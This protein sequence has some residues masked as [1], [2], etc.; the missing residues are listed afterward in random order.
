M[1][2]V[3]KPGNSVTREKVYAAGDVI[4][5]TEAQG[6]AIPWAVEALPEPVPPPPTEKKGK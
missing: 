5:M 6:A 1:K 3:V 2:F 4:E